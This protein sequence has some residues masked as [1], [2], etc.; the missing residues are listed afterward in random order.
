[1]RAKKDVRTISY[2]SSHSSEIIAQINET[3][4]PV[5]I[6]QEGEAKAVLLDTKSYEKMQEAL[7]LLKVLSFGE[8]D[9]RNGNISIQDDFFSELY[10]SIEK[11]D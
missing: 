10:S 4:D 3:R 11:Q 7:S 9:I 8:K 5:F 6:T 1:M 2:I